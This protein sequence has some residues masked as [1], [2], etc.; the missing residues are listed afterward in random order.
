MTQGLSGGHFGGATFHFLNS[1]NSR[2]TKC[3]EHRQPD[4]FGSDG[5]SGQWP[6][7]IRS[8]CGSHGIV[9]SA[10]IQDSWKVTPRLTLNCG[11]RWDGESS[12][13]LLNGTTAAMLDPNT[14]NWIV[15]GGK[16]PPPC[17]A[18][19]GCTRR[20][21]HQQTPA[22]DAII[23]AHVKVAANPNLGPDPT[24][25]DFGPR[26]GFAYKLDDTTVIRGG[27]GLIYDNF[28]RFHP[29]RQGSPVSLA[30]ECLSSSCLQCHR[31]ARGHNG[32]YHSDP[33]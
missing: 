33:K 26:L 15:S 2:P 14:G 10:Y 16:L 28:Y 29:N 6:L 1:R 18:A 23:A 22:T 8:K 25:K 32:R 20:A 3:F 27:Y 31:S 7:S 21:S 19:A 11:L 24:Y 12:P 13:H 17:N 30:V 9:P 5:H 4:G